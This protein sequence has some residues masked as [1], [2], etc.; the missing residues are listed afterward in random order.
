MDD[1]IEVAV[2]VQVI[3]EFEVGSCGKFL[4]FL[5]DFI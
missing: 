5:V 1:L 4:V 2:F 3:V